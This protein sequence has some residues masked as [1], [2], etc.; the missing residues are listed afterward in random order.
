MNLKKI[1]LC[2]IISTIIINGYGQNRELV[3][4]NKKYGYEN[5]MHEGQNLKVILNNGSIITGELR[6][7][8]DSSDL[9]RNNEILLKLESENYYFDSTFKEK[10]IYKINLA[11]IKRIKRPSNAGAVVTVIGSVITIAGI[12]ILKSQTPVPQTNGENEDEAAGIADQNIPK[13]LGGGLAFFV[14]S[15]VT[16]IGGL[17]LLAETSES[18]NCKYWEFSIRRQ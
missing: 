7:S 12:V 9:S 15:I 13:L 8:N 11:D 18:Y 1:L 10:T 5:L 16:I 17:V 6:W 3:L 2:L 4:K 14:G